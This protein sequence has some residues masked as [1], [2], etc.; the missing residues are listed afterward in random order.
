MQVARL[1]DV[2]YC[3]GI[4]PKSN[5][6]KTGAKL[7]LLNLFFV[8]ACGAFKA[9]AQDIHFSQFFETPLLR[10]PGLAGIFSGDMRVQSIYRTQWQSVTVPYQTGSVNGEFKLPVGRADDYL[11]LAGEI[12]YD[13]A[14]TAVLSA[15]HVLPALNYHKS[16]SDQKN[17]YL[18]LG[19]MAGIVQRSIDRSK[20]TTNSQF[21][22][23]S[24]DPGS[25]DGETFSKSSYSYF[26]A[27]TGM[28]FNSQLGDN[29]DNNMYLGVAYQHFNKPSN[30][31][32]YG[33][34]ADELTPKW[35][36]SAGVKTVTSP[37]SYV[38]FQ[39]DYSTQGP[40]TELVA[41]AMLTKKLDDN[42]D[43][44]YL[45]SGGL[46][47]RWQ[48]AVIPVAKLEAKPL[49]ISISYDINTSQLTSASSG[50]GGFE[51]ALSY[52]AFFEHNSSKDAIR[53]PRF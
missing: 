25:I 4:N 17:M 35:V 33:N 18:S 37:D 48:D 29:P 6:M 16:L 32:F 39:G 7:L 46:F 45:I 38:T 10:N 50:R 28:S 52:I 5:T 31:S 34:A 21:I 8:I 43:P 2:D 44:M 22:N 12:L 27:S 3:Q 15:T 24:Y 13:K 36:Y 30:I 47:M 9:N 51:M 41:G 1:Y 26:D 14:G 40:Y 19:F 20:I 23:G 49:S 11:T 42:D 53:C